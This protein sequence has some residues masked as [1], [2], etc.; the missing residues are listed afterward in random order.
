MRRLSRFA[1]AA[2]FVVAGTFH[3][4]R[5]TLYLEIMPPFLPWPSALVAI[6]GAAEILGGLGVL[7][8][9]SRKAAGWG[10]IV[11]LIA[12]FPANLQSVANGMVI[13]R[14]SVPPWILWARLP[15]QLLFVAWVYESCLRNRKA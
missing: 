2:F 10:L 9:S 11:L 5:P 13:D 15:L 14:W 6:S 1:L 12:V 7:F 3:F 8:T 4:V